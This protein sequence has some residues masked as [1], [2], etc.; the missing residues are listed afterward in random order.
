[1]E[2]SCIVDPTPTG[3]KYAQEQGFALY[4]TVDE[5]LNARAEGKV[6]VDG[7]ILAVRLAPSD[8][9]L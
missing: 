2:I 4:K 9:R 1:M 5:L 8:F 6:K 7:V 3:E